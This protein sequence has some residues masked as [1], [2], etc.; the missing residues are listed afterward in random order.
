[1]S[2]ITIV[3]AGMMGS[4]IGIPAAENGNEVRLVGTPLDREIITHA[5]KT[6]EHLTLKRKLP[7]GYKY[8]QIERLKAALENADLLVSGVS[9]FGVEWFEKEVLA[10]IPEALP[11]LSVTKGMQ[12]TEDGGL[13]SYPAWYAARFREKRISLNAVGGPCTSYE[14]ADR[15][16]TEVCFCGEDIDTLRRIRGMFENSYYHI[17]LSTDIAG[18]ECAVALKNAYALGVSLAIGLAQKKEGV[19]GVPHYNSQAALFGQSI[20]EMRKILTLIKAGDENIVWGAGDLYVTIFGGRTR[21]IGTLLGRGFSFEDAME[22]L[23]GIT[24]ESIVI[25]TRTA[26]TVRK[27]ISRKLATESDFPLLLH[28]DDII[29]HGAQVD[30][31]WSK[32]EAET[33]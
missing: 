4:A 17:S 14:L 28:I 25:S 23:K 8:Y 13:I 22:E 16:P 3:G 15:D 32:F 29:N 5:E 27:M 11:V 18:V 10:V 12:D 19:H 6:G 31:P 9:S 1:M 26:R 7:S 24:L 20:K 33:F 21:F 30:I 2:V